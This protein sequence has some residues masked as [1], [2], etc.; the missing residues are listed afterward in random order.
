[1]IWYDMIWYDMIWY[2]MIWYDM[3]WYDM[4]WYDMNLKTYTNLNYTKDFV[5]FGVYLKDWFRKPLLVMTNV[6]DASGSMQW[7]SGCT[8]C[9]RLVLDRGTASGGS[10]D[11]L[12]AK[13]NYIVMTC[14]LLCARIQLASKQLSH[15]IYIYIYI[16]IYILIQIINRTDKLEIVIFDCS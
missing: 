16:Y 9:L 8:A 7:A 6:W 10:A 3:I 1:M 5:C 15:T 11:W 12:S 14:A 2:D 13:W 4:I